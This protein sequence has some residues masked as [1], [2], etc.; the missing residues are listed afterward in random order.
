MKSSVD[1]IRKLEQLFGLFFC[2]VLNTNEHSS[3]TPYFLAN[4]PW[5]CVSVLNN[6]NTKPQLF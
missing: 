1:L 6:T 5:Q 2:F 4:A 3:P